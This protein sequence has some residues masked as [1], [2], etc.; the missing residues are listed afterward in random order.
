MTRLE[1]HIL[2]LLGICWDEYTA[3]QC[4]MYFKLADKLNEGSSIRYEYECAYRQ[5]FLQEWHRI[6][7]EFVR[8]SIIF[9]EVAKRDSISTE[10]A[11]KQMNRI[12]K[13]HH[14]ADIFESEEKLI[15]FQQTI[16]I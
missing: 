9:I 6:D 10:D 2:N 4:D 1:T 7:V 16:I 12:Y 14:T 8:W 15:S 11:V 5:W 13:M 3:Y